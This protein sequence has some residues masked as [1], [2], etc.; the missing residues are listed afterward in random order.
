[1]FI[2][3]LFTIAKIWNQPKC[4]STVECKKKTWYTYTIE[5]YSAIKKEWNLAICNN[6][7]GAREYNGKWN[8]SVQERQ[9]PYDFIL[10]WNLRKQTSKGEKKKEKE[11]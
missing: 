9:I 7:D 5:Y 8:K 2:T 6:L 11:R 10:M 1:M 3:T 4:P